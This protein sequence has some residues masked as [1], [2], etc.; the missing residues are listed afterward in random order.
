MSL[1]NNKKSQGDDI[2]FK[3]LKKT[4]K[5]LSQLSKLIKKV[6]PDQSKANNTLSKNIDTKL[7][8]LEKYEKKIDSIDKF[9]KKEALASLVAQ[10]TKEIEIKHTNLINENSIKNSEIDKLR[11][12]KNKIEKEVERKEHE[13]SDLNEAIEAANRRSKDLKD[14]NNKLKTQTKSDQQFS[15][16]KEKYIQAIKVNISDVPEV[17]ELI[18]EDEEKFEILLNM[19]FGYKNYND[20]KE[21]GSKSNVKDKVVGEESIKSIAIYFS[22]LLIQYGTET[23]GFQDLRSCLNNMI[24]EYTLEDADPIG[25]PVDTERHHVTT[26]EEH[27]TILKIHTLPISNKQLGRITKRAIVDSV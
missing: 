14:E 13:I 2:S 6:G 15:E 21:L 24:E 11:R 17:I 12:E 4:E 23:P 18:R 25:T 9:I 27:N 16:L 19:L 26:D 3:E 22:M 5:L 7:N 20:I 1:L 8:K 10:K